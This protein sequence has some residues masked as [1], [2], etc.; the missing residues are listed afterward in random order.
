MTDEGAA[1]TAEQGPDGDGDGDATG[2]GPGTG[3][4]TGTE[5]ADR[6]DGDDV[7]YRTAVQ[8]RFR[9]IDAFGHV[10]N[11]VFATYCEVARTR[12]LRDRMGVDLSSA[13]VVVA[14]LE[15]D[16]RAPVTD[17]ETVTVAL[18]VSDVGRSSFTLSYD[19]RAEGD[20]V[21][22]AETVQVAV[23]PETGGTRPIPDAWRRVLA[24]VDD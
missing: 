24:T 6:D 8:V 5:N 23:D 2:P 3:T 10:N 9:D 20:R 4:G 16:F 21:A 7:A 22:T 15:V 14:H 12:F 13:G 1:G 11:A 18:N 17:A 19:L